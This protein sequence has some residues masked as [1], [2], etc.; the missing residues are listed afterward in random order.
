MSV[1]YL[2]NGSL[3]DV[4]GKGTA[5][6]QHAWSEFKQSRDRESLSP[7]LILSASNI[8]EMLKV[9]QP[10]DFHVHL[11]QGDFASLVV[12][13]VRQGGFGLAYVM[14]RL[15]IWFFTNHLIVAPA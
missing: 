11:R 7:Y 1:V 15:G 10:S 8:S 5:A 6:E 4:G 9:F 12:P 3:G 14:V 2:D 13:H